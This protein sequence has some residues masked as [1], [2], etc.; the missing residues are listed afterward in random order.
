[1]SAQ[2]WEWEVGVLERREGVAQGFILC[3]VKYTPIVSYGFVSVV[4]QEYQKG[5][6]VFLKFL[7][8]FP[9]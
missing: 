7:T 4:T 2:K 8:N 9:M 5:K 6:S 1:M 3:D